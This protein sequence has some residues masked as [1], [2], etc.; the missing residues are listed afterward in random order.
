MKFLKRAY[1]LSYASAYCINNGY[2]LVTDDNYIN[3]DNPIDIINTKSNYYN[4]S[5]NADFWT[6]EYDDFFKEDLSNIDPKNYYTLIWYKGKSLYI[7]DT[8]N[9]YNETDDYVTYC[10]YD[11]KE[12]REV[13]AKIKDFINSYLLDYNLKSFICNELEI[14]AYR[15]GCYR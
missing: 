3:R 1:G 12:K 13:L 8:Y 5:V 14:G 9:I 11:N 10:T 6:T 15:D 4:H 2:F 7:F